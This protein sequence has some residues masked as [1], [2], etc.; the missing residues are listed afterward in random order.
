MRSRE[1][2]ENK[3]TEVYEKRVKLRIRKY[4]RRSF[5]NCKFNERLLIQDGSFSRKIGT[6]VNDAVSKDGKIF[7]CDKDECANGCRHYQCRHTRES[8]ENDFLDELADPKICGQTEPK[9]AVL[10][11]VLYQENGFPGNTKKGG[12]IKCCKG[13]WNWLRKLIKRD[14]SA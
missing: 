7:I 11:W 9:I 4:L 10:L 3:L 13:F 14:G 5:F 6:C 1:K 2:V 12:K 8:I